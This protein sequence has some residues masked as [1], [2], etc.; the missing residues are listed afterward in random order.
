MPIAIVNQD[1][2]QAIA[3]EQL[4]VGAMFERELLKRAEGAG[5]KPIR[6][7]QYDSLEQARADLLDNK[8]TAVAILPPNLT[9]DVV[10]IGTS[11]G[12]AEPVEATVLLNEGAG[13]L[14]PAVVTKA[15][16][17][18]E[19][20]L[21]GTVSSLLVSQLDELGI[22]VEP[23]NAASI[24]R[25]VRVN[26]ESTPSLTDR[27]GR[28]LPPLYY[29]VVVTLT[30]LLSAVALHLLVGVM[31][32]R[33]E[34]EILGRPVRLPK[35]DLGPW[36]RFK[37]EAS[38]LIPASVLGGLAATATAAW[39]IDTQMANVAMTALVSVLGTLALAWLTL[40][41]ITGFGEL[42]LLVAVLATTIFGVPSARGVYPVEAM[43]AFFSALG[44]LPMRWIVDGARASFYFDGRGAAGLQGSIIVLSLYIVGSLV[45]GVGIARI[46]HRRA[47]TGAEPQ[48]QDG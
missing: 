17:T 22:K 16:N 31:V 36:E 30:G 39:I 9:A 45:C 29:S 12:K 33:E 5:D 25:P 23:G 27:A 2:A 4:S 44:F 10:K 46:C 40:A 8:L 20:E 21:A 28:G 18:A 24:G 48:V 19:A 32:G 13:A 3:G 26:Y 43:P 11:V 41:V 47:A 42:G 38:L 37:V 35:L 14:Q 34:E 15:A 7:I 1:E 6:L